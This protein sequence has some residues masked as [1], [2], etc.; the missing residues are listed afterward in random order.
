M[1]AAITGL[2]TEPVLGRVFRGLAVARE[3]GF[4]AVLQRGEH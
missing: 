1:M 3:A 4:R 2:D